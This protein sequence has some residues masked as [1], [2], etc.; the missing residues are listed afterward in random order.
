M[1]ILFLPINFYNMS[2]VYL[3][4]EGY[5]KLRKELE[6]LKTVKRR[7]ISKAIEYARSLGDLKENAEYQAAKEAQAL[8]EKKIHQLEQKLANAEIID[9]MD[10]AKD[11]VRIGAK[12]K[13]LNLDTEEVEEYTLV[14]PEEAEPSQGLISVY[15]PIGKALLGHKKDDVLEIEVPAGVLKY[16]I[17]DITR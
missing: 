17:L 16:K 13:L 7:E 3:T 15:S 1:E 6:Y 9:D 8:N 2:R 5:E 11:E 12:V 14:S 4:R 10:I